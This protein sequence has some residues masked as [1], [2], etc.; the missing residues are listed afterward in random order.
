MFQ[1]MVK[2]RYLKDKNLFKDKILLKVI[3]VKILNGK[4]R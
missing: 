4:V 1:H 2:E 3:S